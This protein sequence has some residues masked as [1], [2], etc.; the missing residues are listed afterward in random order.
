MWS[1][2][3]VPIQ[4]LASFGTS[5]CLTIDF[6]YEKKE[7]MHEKKGWEKTTRFCR[8]FLPV[9]LLIN[10]SPRCQYFFPT[11]RHSL[12]DFK[13]F[14]TVSQPRHA[15]ES[16][17]YCAIDVELL[18]LQIV[19]IERHNYL[20]DYK[21]SFSRLQIAPSHEQKKLRS[22]RKRNQAKE[23]K[24]DK[25]RLHEE[26]G[27]KKPQGF[28]CFLP[29]YWWAFSR[30]ANVFRPP[31]FSSRHLLDHGKFTSLHCSNYH[32]VQKILPQTESRKGKEKKQM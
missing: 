15:R 26:K 4:I 11:G 17:V 16:F 19:E 13:C 5:F 10:S 23:R 18:S 14:L 21:Y 20:L 1:K 3:C 22:F 8:C 12:L 29:R 30:C 25:R 24:K 9:T 28:E 27:R 2:Q 32:D 6:S 31:K 7:S